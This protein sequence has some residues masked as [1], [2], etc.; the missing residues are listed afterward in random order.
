[1]LLADALAQLASS[2]KQ[3]LAG[4]TDVF[5]L[6]WPAQQQF[7]NIARVPELKTIEEHDVY[8]RIGAAVTWSDLAS[9]KLPVLFDGLIAAGKEVGSIQ[10]QNAAT[11][12]GNVCN[13]SPAADG[14]PVLIAM[15]AEIEITDKSGTRVLPICEFVLGPRSIALK[16]DQLVVAIRIPKKPGSVTSQFCKLGSRK[17]LVISF[18][19]IAA[20]IAVESNFITSA[21]IA[22]GSCSPVACRLAS[23]EARLVN[24]PLQ[25]LSD[26]EVT[27]EADLAP[28]TPIDD[29]RATADYRLQA[30]QSLLQRTLN[31]IPENQA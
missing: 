15:D 5:T 22:V 30:A 21:G 10:I 2:D 18:V 9:A 13:A 20:V 29:K 25:V 24:Q 16:P 17:Y 8:W 1:M 6:D 12:V 4:G 7:I 27:P 3:V 31:A 28:L 19:S 26:I 23:L 11:I 14:T